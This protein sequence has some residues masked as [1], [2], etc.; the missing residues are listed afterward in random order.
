NPPK[1]LILAQ[2]DVRYDDPAAAEW[3]SR[4]ETVISLSL[5]PDE[6]TQNAALALP[7]QSFAERDGTYTNGARR[8]QRFYT[9]QGPMGEALPAW[10]VIS[11]IGERLEQGR[12]K[13]S[14]AAVMLEI[15]QSIPAF[16]G[17]RYNELAR[18]EPQFPE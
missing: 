10:Q 13:A 3:L 2:A 8:V 4:V 1:A 7:V 5:F 15:T 12:A 16:A 17:M 11:R 14:A 9:A 6:A 18:V